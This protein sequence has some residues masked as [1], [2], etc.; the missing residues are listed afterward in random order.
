MN[1]VFKKIGI[2]LV[3]L[4]L[5][6]CTGVNVWYI[7][8]KEF[9]PTKTAH[10]IY[11][12]AELEK[13]DGSKKNIFEI[14]YYSNKN[15]NGFECFELKLT[16]F[17]DTTREDTD[18]IGL[19]YIANSST[20]N[21]EWFD[22]EK[23][24]K[25]ADGVMYGA[26]NS[27]RLGGYLLDNLSHFTAYTFTSNTKSKFLWKGYYESFY[28]SPYINEKSTSFYSYDNVNE[29]VFTP[30]VLRLDKSSSFLLQIGEDNIGMRLKFDN[31]LSYDDCFGKNRVIDPL[32]EYFSH[33]AFQDFSRNVYYNYNFDFLSW[34]LYSKVLSLPAGENYT[35]FKFDDIFYYYDVSDKEVWAQKHNIDYKLIQEEITS[36]YTIKINVSDDGLRKASDSMFNIVKGSSEFVVDDSV[37]TD[38]FSG[39]QIVNLDI[40]AFDLVN[41]SDNFYALKLKKEI[42]DTYISKKKS[43][44]LSITIDVSVLKNQGKEYSGLI[45]DEMLNSFEIQET[46]IINSSEVNV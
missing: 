46:K 9:G 23:I 21:I 41:V 16:E 34:Y 45:E 24:Y 26:L 15:K 35:T 38:Y 20:D 29:D 32:D 33:N 31:Y 25:N 30:K 2:S 10:S 37:V 36:Y 4:L 40:F 44:L 1:N 13:A 11:K 17:T 22:F 28:Y 18:S 7:L 14:N 8:I 27:G 43:I 19:Q 12:G 6:L 3:V 42:Y 5:V 39:K